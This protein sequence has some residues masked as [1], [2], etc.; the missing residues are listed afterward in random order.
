MHCLV[1]DSAKE[2]GVCA[3]VCVCVCVL[4]VCLTSGP[5]CS[6][7]VVRSVIWQSFIFR[8][9]LALSCIQNKHPSHQ[10]APNSHKEIKSIK[11]K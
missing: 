4:C 7:C 11:Y 10:P 1:S 9:A 2:V 3:C 6:V 8:A 5:M